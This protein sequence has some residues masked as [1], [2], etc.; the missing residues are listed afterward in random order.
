[1]W[2]QIVK[3]TTLGKVMTRDPST[4][5]PETSLRDALKLFVEERIGCL[6]VLEGGK[7]VGIVTASD[8][9]KACLDALP[10]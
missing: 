8:L 6:P 9:F 5:T 7:L 3:E 1:M 2:E 4:A 10:A